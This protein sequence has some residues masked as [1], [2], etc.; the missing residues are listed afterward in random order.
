[1]VL[2]VHRQSLVLS[3]CLTATAAGFASAALADTPTTIDRAS[4]STNTDSSRI[5][6]C[7]PFND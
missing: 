3:L 1:M 5:I 7:S 6:R 2:S 4:L